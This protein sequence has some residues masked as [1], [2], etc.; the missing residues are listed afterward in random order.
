M[1]EPK[2]LIVDDPTAG[3]GI[4]DRERIVGLLRSAAEDGGV[5]VL[6]AVPDMPAML[7]A[8]QLRFLSRGRLLAP[9]GSTDGTV[10]DFPGDKRTA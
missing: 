2:L 1:R 8:H 3:L 7:H 10:L 4:I 6:M 5:G 9:P